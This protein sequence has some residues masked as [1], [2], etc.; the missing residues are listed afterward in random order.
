[1]PTAVPSTVGLA[2]GA[3]EHRPA[4][5]DDRERSGDAFVIP[6]WGVQSSYNPGRGSMH[7]THYEY[8]I[9][10]PLLFWGAVKAGASDAPATPYDLAPTVARWLG[11]PVPDAVGK[12]IDLPK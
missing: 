12:P 9:L 6:R 8:D 3:H 10:V 5:A 1:M 2:A 7:G 11:V 4:E